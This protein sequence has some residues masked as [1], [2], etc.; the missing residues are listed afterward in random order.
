LQRGD[1]R[2]AAADADHPTGFA[3]EFARATQQPVERQ[4]PLD[5][6]MQLVFGGE[7]DAA[8]H[9]LARSRWR[10]SLRGLRRERQRVDW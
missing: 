4:D 3:G 1:A 8:K 5:V 6:P 2:G 7:P 9:L 10:A